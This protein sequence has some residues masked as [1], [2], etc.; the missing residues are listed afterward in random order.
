MSDDIYPYE[1]DEERHPWSFVFF[2]VN[3]AARFDLDTAETLAKHIEALGFDRVNESTIKYDAFGTSGGPWEIGGWI[4][5]EDE[6]MQV[7]VNIPP[8]DITDY[9]DEEIAEAEAAL[10]ALK[11]ARAAGATRKDGGDSSGG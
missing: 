4:K 6:R 3:G 7:S 2:N 9:S 10:S 1:V 5:V 11:S 8:K